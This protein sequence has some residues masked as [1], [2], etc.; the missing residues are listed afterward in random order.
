MRVKDDTLDPAYFAKMPRKASGG[1][2]SSYDD[3][4]LRE[5]IRVLQ[6]TINEM[7]TVINNTQ[8]TINEMQTT[9]N[10]MQIEIDELKAKQVH[11][12]LTAAEYESLSEE[13]KL[14]DME[15]FVT[16]G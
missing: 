15:Y 7:Q 8:T 10:N 2:G 9:I 11:T 14:K 6:V 12:E 4:E 1:T 3:S 5:M 16:E 13:D